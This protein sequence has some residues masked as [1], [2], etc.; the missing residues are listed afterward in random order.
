M[1]HDSIAIPQFAL[2]GNPLNYQERA[3]LVLR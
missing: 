1:N 2:D 3:G